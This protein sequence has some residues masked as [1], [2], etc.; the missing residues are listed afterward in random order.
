MT[1]GSVCPVGLYPTNKRRDLPLERLACV[2]RKLLIFTILWANSAE[3]FCFD[4]FQIP[5]G[6]RIVANNQS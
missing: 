4:R 3:N 1:A 2:L 6:V 5:A